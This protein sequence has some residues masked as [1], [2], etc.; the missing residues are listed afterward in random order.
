MADTSRRMPN[1]I[2]LEE[3]VREWAWRKYDQTATRKQ[4]SLRDKE[5]RKNEKYI[6]VQI[7]WDEVD[8]RDH[9]IWSQ[10]G[11]EDNFPPSSSAASSA[12]ASAGGSTKN[13]PTSVHQNGGTQQPRAP[14]QP[15]TGAATSTNVLFHTDF[16]N[17]THTPQTYTMRVDKTTRSTCTTEVEHGVCKGFDLSV[18]LKLPCEIMEANAGYHREVSLTKTDGQTFEEEMS[19]GAESEIRVES[20]H[21]ANAQLVVREK[22]KSGN[23]VIESRLRGSVHVT[24]TKLRENNSLL[25]PVSGDIAFIVRK[26]LE[27]KA[28]I[29]DTF[30]FVTVQDDDT[31]LIKTKGVCKFCYGIKQ[32]VKVDQTPL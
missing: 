21:M 28:R 19:W 18:S 7:D 14:L 15:P 25:K 31:V 4:R 11:D 10:V 6:G 1:F 16:T 29:G 9:T 17:N 13:G 32:E 12:A 2:D 3:M 23:F 24:F 20:R 5:T 27:Q 30:N 26:Y 22:K 8:A